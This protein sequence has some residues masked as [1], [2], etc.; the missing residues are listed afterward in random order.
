MKQNT[1][2]QFGLK[3]STGA[4]E[5]TSDSIKRACNRESQWETADPLTTLGS[6]PLPEGKVSG[7][8]T[9]S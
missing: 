2:T 4:W 3:T 9:S 5:T 6:L 8:S 7:M 1:G